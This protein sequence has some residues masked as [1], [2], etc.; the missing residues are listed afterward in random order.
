MTNWISLQTIISL[1]GDMIKIALPIIFVFGMCNM[2]YDML[3]SAAFGGI[4]RIGRGR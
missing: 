4:M 3:T 2:V 1:Y